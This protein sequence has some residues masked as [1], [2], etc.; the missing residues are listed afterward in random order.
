MLELLMDEIR[1]GGTLEI[2]Q[3]AK[4]LNTT[5]QL[6]ELMIEHLQ[7]SGVVKPYETCT[8][9]CSR[10][11]LSS[12]CSHVKGNGVTQIWE[13]EENLVRKSKVPG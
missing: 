1:K 10:C 4:K 7:H 5:P 6:V 9:G 12:A 2:N 3:L 8:D 13:Y 11:Q